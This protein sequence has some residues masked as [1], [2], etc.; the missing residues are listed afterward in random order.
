V[1]HWSTR[2][3]GLGENDNL[4]KSIDDAA[5]SLNEKLLLHAL[6]GKKERKMKL[7]VGVR[8]LQHNQS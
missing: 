1:F 6:Y 8:G 2:E 3:D 5:P 4:D 7:E